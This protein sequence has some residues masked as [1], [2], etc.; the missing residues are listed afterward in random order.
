MIQ[1]KNKFLLF[2]LLFGLLVLGGCGKQNTDDTTEPTTAPTDPLQQTE[3]NTGTVVPYVIQTDTSS[4]DESYSISDTLFGLFLEDINFAVDGGMYAELVKNR[5]FEYGTIATQQEKH[6]WTMTDLSGQLE[7]SVVDGLADNSCLNENNPHYV[8]LKNNLS[9]VQ[10]IYNRGYLDGMSVTVGTD[11]IFSIYLKAPEGYNG[12]VLVSINTKENEY[13]TG[14]VSGLTNEWRKYELTLTPSAADSP[15]G[16]VLSNVRLTVMIEPGSTVCA[17]M[18]SL[19]TTDTYKGTKIRRDIGEALEKLEPSFLRFP[20]GCVIEGKDE[21]S[22]YS[23]KD[24]IGDG[25]SFDINGETTVGDVAIRP[26]GR[27]IWTGTGN[28]PYYTTYGIGFYEYFELCDIL[29]CMPLPVLNA[30]MTCQVQSPKYI[31]YDVTSTKFKQ[32]VQDA[33]DLVEFCRGDASTTW[34]SVRIAM[35]HEEPFDLKYI[36]IGNEQWQTE[37]FQ[38]YQKFEEAFLAAAQENPELYGD[39][40]L[41]VANGTSSGDSCGWD[42]VEFKA[43]EITT[44]VDEHYYEAPSFFF[45]NTN[46][47]DSYDRSLNAKVFLGEY[48]SQS[49]TLESALSEAAYMTGLEKN[50]DVVELACYAPLFGNKTQNQW[51]PDLIWFD[52]DSVY[53]SINYY[54]QQLFAVNSGLTELPTTA[55]ASALSESFELSGKVGLGTWQTKAAFD[56]LTVTD[57]VSGEVLYSCTFDESAVL[58][59]DGYSINEGEWEIS[60]GRLVQNNTAAPF[61]T[62]TGDAIY[63]GDTTWNNYTLTVE[64]EILSGAEGFLIPVC[65]ENSDNN[66]FW[67]IGGWGNTVSCLQI[68]SSGAKSGQVSGTTKTLKLKHNQVYTLKVVVNGTNIQCFIDDKKYVDYTYEVPKPIYESAVVAE[69]GDLIIKLINTLDTP[70]SFAT[71]LSDFDSSAFEAQASV[72]VLAGSKLSDTNTFKEPD[73]VVPSETSIAVSAEFSYEAPAYSLSVIRIKKK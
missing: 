14:V 27:S 45:S 47:Y 66:I 40:E 26:Q 13:A 25:L 54:V 24:S 5:S 33:L 9:D 23:W 42:Y 21:E 53:G 51:T 29:G 11:Y 64:A 37:Y 43:S 65:V 4:L 60:D 30:G 61:D 56:N 49:N 58:N 57:N 32:C 63:V 16:T 36:A 48:A 10:G 28:H 72:T 2:C 52:T 41:V 34:G 7:F 62:N 70:V 31:V 6:G 67:N 19:L 20:G 17:D 35:G 44:L 68:V 38:H 22:M 8:M 39:I 18:I 12:D 3:S 73:K 55:D 59:N 69:N 50:G 46:R 1:K 71:T 15:T